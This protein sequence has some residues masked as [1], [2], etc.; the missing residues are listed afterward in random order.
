MVINSEQDVTALNKLCS[1][2]KQA[3]ACCKASIEVSFCFYG[4]SSTLQ[5]WIFTPEVE[6]FILDLSEGKVESALSWLDEKTKN[7]FKD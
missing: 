6:F 2:A 3:E 1:L 5:I 4:R 7:L